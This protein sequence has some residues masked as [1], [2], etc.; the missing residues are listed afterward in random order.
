MVSAGTNLWDTP[1]LQGCGMLVKTQCDQPDLHWEPTMQRVW[2]HASHELCLGGPHQ[3]NWWSY[4]PIRSA[5]KTTC[6]VFG[7]RA[8]SICIED[9]QTIKRRNT[10]FWADDQFLDH[11]PYPFALKM[12]RQL[13]G[14]MRLSERTTRLWTKRKRG[15]QKFSACR[16]E[17][18]QKC[19]NL[20]NTMNIVGWGGGPEFLLLNYGARIECC[21]GS[22]IL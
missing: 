3:L 11:V 18:H 8:L 20:A 10:T 19:R 16:Y 5:A 7:P 4:H 2:R 15:V 22:R 17:Q 9:G 13:K 1:H 12:D 21:Q 6:T 14:G